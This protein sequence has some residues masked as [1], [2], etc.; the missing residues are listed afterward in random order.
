MKRKQIADE[1]TKCEPKDDVPV[2]ILRLMTFHEEGVDL[3]YFDYVLPS[4]LPEEL[5]PSLDFLKTIYSPTPY[6]NVSKHTQS[7]DFKNKKNPQYACLANTAEEVWDDT[8]DTLTVVTQL[9]KICGEPV[10]GKVGQY[11]TVF[12]PTYE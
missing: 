9:E 11:F 7:W 10:V 6:A 3:V 5:D 8:D 4:T 1:D 2:R 12:V